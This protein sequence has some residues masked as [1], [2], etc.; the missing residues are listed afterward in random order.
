[1]RAAWLISLSALLVGCAS[2]QATEG[3]DSAAD[4]ERTA[5]A[6][7]TPLACGDPDLRVDGEPP[8]REFATYTTWTRDGC[9]VRIDYLAE[10]VDSDCD[11]SWPTVLI[12][13][14][15]VGT[16]YTNAVDSLTYLR[17]DGNLL[18]DGGTPKAVEPTGY[19][20]EDGRELWMDPQ[21]QK[22]AYIVSEARVERWPLGEEEVCG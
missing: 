21:D 9:L 18:D 11:L 13:G 15:P 8:W 5:D 6:P 10:R 17:D 14:D 2:E 20:A 7:A 16:P 22:A 19:V 1:M 12:T 3:V 4:E